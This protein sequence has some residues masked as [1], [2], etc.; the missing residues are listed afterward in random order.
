MISTA[1]GGV[2]VLGICV[3]MIV[4]FYK[5]RKSTYVCKASFSNQP[6]ARLKWILGGQVYE[7]HILLH[8]L[9]NVSIWKLTVNWEMPTCII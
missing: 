9:L 2:V 8:M 1:G 7:T 4:V 3:L 5:R 6:I